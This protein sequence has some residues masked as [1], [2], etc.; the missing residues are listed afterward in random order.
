MRR[1][2]IAAALLLTT[3]S[4]GCQHE[5][6][7]YESRYTS[8]QPTSPPLPPGASYFDDFNRP[9]TPLGVGPGWQ[10]GPADGDPS[11][12]PGDFGSVQGGKLIANGDGGLYAM[13]SF[14]SIVRRVGVTGGWTRNTAGGFETLVI[15][16]PAKGEFAPGMVR[17]TVNPS[18]W[19][20]A[21]R[22]GSERFEPIVGGKFDPALEVGREYRFEIDTAD[23]TVAVR[24][25]GTDRRYRVGT[26]G[27]LGDRAFWQ[28]YSDPTQRPVGAKFGINS[29]WVAEQDQL[30][31]PVPS[32]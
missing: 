27:L 19:A 24:V 22:R 20:L 11:P 26:L 9:M 31:S 16:V 28:V 2:W 32:E 1:K 18:R 6:P 4:A 17:L 10:V 14:R 5:G 3:V 15:G 12:A 30:L 13:R 21:T 23:G 29:V 8:P 7:P 25:P